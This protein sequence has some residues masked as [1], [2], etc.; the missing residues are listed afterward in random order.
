LVTYS[1]LGLFVF[2]QQEKKKVKEGTV[3]NVGVLILTQI[4]PWY[5]FLQVV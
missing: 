4:A 5:K 2:N 1:D 3:D